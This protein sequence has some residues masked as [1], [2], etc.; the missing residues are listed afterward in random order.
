MNLYDVKALAYVLH[1]LTIAQGA[2]SFLKTTVGGAKKPEGTSLTKAVSALEFAQKFFQA[3]DVGKCRQHVQTAAKQWERPLVDVSGAIEILHRLQMDILSELDSKVFLLVAEGRSEF[4]DK[5]DLFGDEVLSAFGAARRDIKE[6]GNCLAAECNTGAVF[7]LMRASE[8][9]L[10]AVAKDRQ[11]MFSN[12]PVEH[13]EWGMILGSLE[14][15]L[16]SMRLSDTQKWKS[17]LFKEAQ[18]RFYND[19]VQE[20]RGFNEAWRRHVAHAD[21]DAFYDHEQAKN[22]LDHVRNFMQ[23]LATRIDETKTTPLY[24][25]T[26]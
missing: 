15:I 10:R 18:V 14:G 13:Q 25:E 26:E 20:L 17:P 22:V 1:D 2:L 8:V 5:E 11:V 24:W 9:A 6:A 21:V 4:I 12:K 16:K 19:V 3:Y 23:K 7:H